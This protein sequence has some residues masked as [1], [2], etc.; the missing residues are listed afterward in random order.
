MLIGLYWE[1]SASNRIILAP[2]G[3]KLQAVGSYLVKALHPDIHIEYP[4]PEGFLA[5]YSS[6]I[7]SKWTLSLGELPLLFDALRNAETREF[8]GDCR[9][10]G[11][12]AQGDPA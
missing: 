3:S 6:G 9:V 2:S 4:C 8:F 7:G 10:N 11:D 1:L 5:V 12:P